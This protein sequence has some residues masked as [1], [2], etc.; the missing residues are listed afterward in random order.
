MSI[1]MRIKL[2]RL[3]AVAIGMLAAALISIVFHFTLLPYNSVVTVSVAIIV[4]FITTNYFMR[5]KLFLIWLRRFHQTEKNQ[6][7]FSNVISSACYDMC[8]PVTI[9]DSKFKRSYIGILSKWNL[10]FLLFGN[11]IILFWMAIIL[12]LTLLTLP[13]IDTIFPHMSEGVVSV[14]II[15]IMI[16]SGFIIFSLGYF[17]RERLDLRGFYSIDASTGKKKAERILSKIVKRLFVFH[18]ILILKCPDEA[19]REIVEFVVGRANAVLIDVS[20]PTENILWEIE[21]VFKA[22]AKDSIVIACGIGKNEPEEMPTAAKEALMHCIG[23]SDLSDLRVFY[24]PAE[25]PSFGLKRGRAWNSFVKR[26]REEIGSV[27]LP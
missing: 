7:R 22:K 3:R 2:K 6:F 24:Y 21:T 25:K 8:I 23:K 1:A 9:Q 27:M 15:S 10:M 16:V 20:K 12:V 18:G 14:F 19:W 13:I 11:F 17:F 26:F 4:F 5:T